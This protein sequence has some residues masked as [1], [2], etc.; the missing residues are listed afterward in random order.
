MA[1]AR[2]PRRRQAVL[3]HPPSPARGPARLQGRLPAPRSA[4]ADDGRVRAAELRLERGRSP[5]SRL[6]GS[7]GR[8]DRIALPGGRPAL[9]ARSPGNAARRALGQ[10]LSPPRAGLRGRRCE[11]AGSG[12]RR[13]PRARAR[14]RRSTYR[15]RARVL[16][17]RGAAPLRAPW[18]AARPRPAAGRAE[19]R[20]AEDQPLV[21]APA[22]SLRDARCPA[23]ALVRGGRSAAVRSRAG[24][25]VEAAMGT[26]PRGS[27]SYARWWTV[28]R[29]ERR[30]CAAGAGTRAKDPGR[31]QSYGVPRPAAGVARPIHGAARRE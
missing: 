26:P 10:D 8:A 29:D 6:A 12:A 17:T 20:P 15:R 18:K 9:P 31:S 5:L 2:P 11:S 23:G 30:A 16:Q 14:A 19:P 28:S 21:H 1:T 3:A 13:A 4:P 7:G 25:R 24:R 22:G 27:G